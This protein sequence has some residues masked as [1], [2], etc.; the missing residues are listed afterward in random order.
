[1]VTLLVTNW[2]VLKYLLGIGTHVNHK[3]ILVICLEYHKKLADDP[4]HL[5]VK[6]L[7]GFLLPFFAL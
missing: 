5:T 3:N 1:M 7:V 6:I 4:I 2:Q